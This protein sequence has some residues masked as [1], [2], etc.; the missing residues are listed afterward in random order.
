M[1]QTLCTYILLVCF[2]YVP[3]ILFT[4]HLLLLFVQYRL[5]FRGLL[6]IEVTREI[7]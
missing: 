5:V 3:N 6:R 7:S 4:W 1:F 2:D